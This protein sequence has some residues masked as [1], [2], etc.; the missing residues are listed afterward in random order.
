[1][2]KI[3]VNTDGGARGNPGPSGVGILIRQSD[4]API[5]AFSKFLGVATN[6]FAEYEAVAQA[7]EAIKKMYGA[8]TKDL[9]VEVRLDSELVARQLKGEYQ[10]K[11]QTL[12]PQYIRV[13]NLLVSA[14]PHVSF[15]Y[16]PREQ[17]KEADRLANEAMDTG[18][19]SFS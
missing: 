4:G 15:V 17:N 8:K 9:H 13:H 7:L 11:E 19:E 18:G 2:E 16:V 12:F 14:F 10:V 1:M 3:L 5:K 6:N